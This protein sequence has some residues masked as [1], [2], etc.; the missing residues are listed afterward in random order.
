MCKG[1]SNL[2]FCA[3]RF[4]ADATE[5]FA[6]TEVDNNDRTKEVSDLYDIEARSRPLW[7][8]YP[9][10]HIYFIQGWTKFDFPGRGDKVFTSSCVIPPTQFPSPGIAIAVQQHEMEL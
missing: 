9:F 5:R 1:P 2:L 8:V 3:V 7:L 6:V 4:G 10:N